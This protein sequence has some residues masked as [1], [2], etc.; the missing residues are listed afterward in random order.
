MAR[1]SK[2]GS[3]KTKKSSKKRNYV[4]PGFTRQVGY[5]GRYNGTP[6]WE[7][8]WFDTNIP[9]TAIPQGGINFGSMNIV[10]QNGASNGR[11][12]RKIV[13]TNLMLNYYA[14]RAADSSF[15]VFRITVVLDK[16]ANGAGA[17]FGDVWQ[18]AGDLTSYPNMVN[19]QR[20]SILYDKFIDLST[21]A[22]QTSTFAQNP[23]TTTTLYAPT[24]KHFKW[25]KRVNIPVEFS[26]GAVATIANVKSNNIIVYAQAAS[27][28]Q[29][30][31]NIN[32][33][34]RIR[35]SDS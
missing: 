31:S 20:F 3:K 16:Q 2:K 27:G 17:G 10:Q 9:A 15:T 6:G 26:D 33:I 5:F 13:I 4:K 24:S 22:V 25:S 23:I 8:K 7:R 11:I 12:G 30:A 34:F 35:Y 32:G 18:D 19:T 1:Y 21:S 14:N 29:H 28:G